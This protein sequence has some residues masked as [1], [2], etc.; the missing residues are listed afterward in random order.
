MKDKIIKLLTELDLEET[1][2]VYDGLKRFI[3]EHDFKIEVNGV[4]IFFDGSNDAEKMTYIEISKDM[5]G[6]RTE[7]DCRQTT[8]AIFSYEDIQNLEFKIDGE[9]HYI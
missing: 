5:I 7:Y 8:F 4:T 3:M 6:F 2:P 1:E 9:Y